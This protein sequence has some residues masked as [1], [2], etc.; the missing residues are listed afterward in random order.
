[1]LGGGATPTAIHGTQTITSSS[2]DG[3]TAWAVNMYNSS[4]SDL[5]FVVYAVCATAGP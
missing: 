4:G 3:T 1:V 5:H 2:P